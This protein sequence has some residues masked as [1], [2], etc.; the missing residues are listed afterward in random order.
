QLGGTITPKMNECR[1]IEVADGNG[2][3]LMNMRSYFG[4]G[5]R[6]QSASY[7]GGISWTA[8]EDIPELVE[9]VCQ[10]SLIRYRRPGSKGEGA[11]LFLNPASTTKRHNLTLRASFDEGK[12]WPVIRTVFPGPSAYSSMAV[13]SDGQILCLYEAGKNGAY[14]Q[15]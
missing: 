7:D 6:A 5:R 10:A 15:I 1:V 8:P 2:T 11:M 13:L 3:L 4:R 14:E 9:P 12:T